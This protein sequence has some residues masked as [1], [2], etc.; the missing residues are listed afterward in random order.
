M[1]NPKFSIVVP[2]YNK[3]NQVSETIRSVLAQQFCD[4][5]IIVVDDGSTDGSAAIV[6]QF[7]DR[8][9]RVRLIRHKN[10]HVS[11]ARNRGIQASRGDIIAF[12]DADDSW[13]DDHLF[14][15][16]KL[17]DAYPEAGLLGTGYVRRYA[18]GRPVSF[19]VKEFVGTHGLIENYFEL[20]SEAQFIYTSSIAIPRWAIEQ[21]QGF[22][23]NDLKFTEDLEMWFRFAVR[24]PVAYS[25]EAT[26]NYSCDVPGQATGSGAVSRGLSTEFTSKVIDYI[27]RAEDSPYARIRDVNHYLQSKITS[28]L[29]IYLMDNAFTVSIYRKFIEESRIG[30][31][32]LSRINRWLVRLPSPFFWKPYFLLKRFC[33]SRKYLSMRGGHHE[34]HGISYSFYQDSV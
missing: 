26:V 24:W 1:S 27:N 21:E 32:Q 29:G 15:L 4:F 10:G 12:L 6:E 16:S 11:R 23:E 30:N 20:T 5:E 3:E 2:L 28:L 8:D 31:L 17:S 14:E 22:N 13:R 19:L 7:V 9:S 34:R 18:T 33:G 25:G